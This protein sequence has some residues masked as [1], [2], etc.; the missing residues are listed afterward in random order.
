MKV[1]GRR[2]RLARLPPPKLD[3]ISACFINKLVLGVSKSPSCISNPARKRWGHRLRVISQEFDYLWNHRDG[4]HR[5]ACFP[6]FRAL[7]VNPKPLG[8]VLLE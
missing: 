7:C 2:H 3:R 1:F 8:N 5:Y 6:V 4:G